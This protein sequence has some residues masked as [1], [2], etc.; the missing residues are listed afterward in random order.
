M[1]NF[2]CQTDIKQR[3]YTH[4]ELEK[5]IADTV[6]KMAKDIASTLEEQSGIPL[7]SP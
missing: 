3:Q 6:M 7:S 5:Q 1:W 4:T 2:N